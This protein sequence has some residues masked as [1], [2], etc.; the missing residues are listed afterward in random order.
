MQ[1][2]HV[3]HGDSDEQEGW[4]DVTKYGVRPRE[5]MFI[6]HAEG[7]SMEPKIHD[8]D[9]CVFTH[10]DVGGSRNGKI[11]LVESNKH[12]CRHVIKEYHSIKVYDEDSWAH[13]S[14]LLHSLNPEYDD[15]ELTEDDEPRIAGFFVSVLG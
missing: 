12:D 4:L 10:T 14:I 3:N 11:V 7:H 2:K 8:G 6:V 9:L 15:I 1:Y 5:G 13:E